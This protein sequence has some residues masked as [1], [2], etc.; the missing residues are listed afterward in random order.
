MHQHFST[1]SATAIEGLL[2]RMVSWRWMLIAAYLV[3]SGLLIAGAWHVSRSR[4]LSRRRCGPVSPADASPRRHAHRPHRAICQASAATNRSK[5]S[6]PRTSISTLGYVG[7]I[8]S[9]FPVNAVYQWSRG[10]EEVILYVGLNKRLGIRDE[11][12]K[13]RLRKRLSAAHARGAFLVRAVRHRQRSDE[14]WLADSGRDR[15]QRP[16]FCRQPAVR[17][18]GAAGAGARFRSCA[19]LQFGQSL[20]Y[21]TIDVNVD[22]EKAGLAGLDAGRR[23]AGTRDGH[24]I[25]PVHGSEL[26]GRS[27]ERHR[28][29]GASRNSA[30]PSSANRTVRT[31]SARPTPWPRS[32]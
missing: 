25:E 3:G 22:R 20:D 31:P 29:P 1:G 2:T 11:E 12:L 13:E 21:P 18:K 5:K 17:R 9:N 4:N 23:L 24:F 28:L 19:I 10:P 8:H 26:L 16:G 14:L 15:R 6:A 27:Q 30:V 32:R 7:M